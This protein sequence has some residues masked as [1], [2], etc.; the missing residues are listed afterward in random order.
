M[1][2]DITTKQESNLP[3]AP[4]GA[5][6]AENITAEDILIPR[7][8]LMQPM[9]DFVT[10]GDCKFGDV[11]DSLEKTKVLAND[12]KALELVVFGQFKTWRVEHDGEF[13]RTYPH[14]PDNAH[15][16]Y[17][18]LE[19][20][21]NNEVMVTNIITYNYYALSVEDI[22]LGKAFP[23]VISFKSSSKNAGKALGA[24]LMR[25]Q[26]QNKPSAAQVFNLTS[27][28]E[29]NDKGTFAVFEVT[30]GR[31]TTELEVATTYK[32]YQQLAKAVDKV[33]IDQDEEE[34]AQTAKE[35][36][37]TAKGAKTQRQVNDLTV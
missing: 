34:L 37:S 12:K 27:K 25:L 18:K 35:A 2:K 16:E 9:S 32:W 5:W 28:K 1:A 23:Y 19:Q 7:L 20:I 33:K 26:A 6:G 36:K 10:A 11:I 31:D 24:H 21:G 13:F 3:A 29:T 8:L 22:K 17:E 15:W 30:P 4:M 14:G